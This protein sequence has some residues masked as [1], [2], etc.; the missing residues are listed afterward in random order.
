MY[1]NFELDRI[2]V[3]RLPVFVVVIVIVLL[4]TIRLLAA[5]ILLLFLRRRLVI[6]VR[7]RPRSCPEQEPSSPSNTDVAA[8]TSSVLVLSYSPFLLCCPNY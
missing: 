3:Y 7:Y 2:T 5:P 4:G 8:A 6:V 1:Y